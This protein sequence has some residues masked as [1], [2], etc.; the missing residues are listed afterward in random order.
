MNSQTLEMEMEAAYKLSMLTLEAL[1][2][3]MQPNDSY[4]VMD[5]E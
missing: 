2:C 1:E 3:A 5:H 4:E